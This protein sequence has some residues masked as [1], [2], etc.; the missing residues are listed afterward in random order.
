MPLT[1]PTW[2]D[3]SLWG[4][5][6]LWCSFS[7]SH[8]YIAWLE[9]KDRNALITWNLES[10]DAKVWTPVISTSGVVSFSDSFGTA[11]DVP[12]AP[13]P[14]GVNWTPSISNAGIVTMTSGADAA[15]DQASLIDSDSIQWWWSAFASGITQ[16]VTN[17]QVGY[18]YKANLVAV[19]VEYDD[20]DELVIDR[21]TALANITREVPDQ[22]VAYT[23]FVTHK[24]V[25]VEIVYASGDEIVIDHIQVQCQVK[26]HMPKG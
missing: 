19:E 26:K 11:T 24:K 5:G 14:T 8:Q 4:D 16:W 13:D 20:G 18:R 22:F 15:E 1:C 10:P 2:G 7:G 25:S 3:S 12:V 23:D 17:P 21:I 6:D 9:G